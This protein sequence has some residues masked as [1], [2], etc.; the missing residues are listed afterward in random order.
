[1]VARGAIVDQSGL[2]I[3]CANP[4]V[5]AKDHQWVTDFAAEAAAG[6]RAAV[7]LDFNPLLNPHIDRRALLAM[8]AELD[9]RAFAIE[10]LGQ[11]RGPKDAVAYNWV[12]L[13]NERPVPEDFIDVTEQFLELA[14]EGSGISH[15]V[16]LDVQRIPY[17]GGPWYK[18][19]VR[20]GDPISENSVIAWIVGETVLEGGDE[21]EFCDGMRDRGLD[22][23]STLIVCD[24]SGR[25]KHSRRT[26]SNISPEWSGQGSFDTIRGEGFTRIVPPDRRMNRNPAIVD[27]VRAFTSMISTGVGVRRL[28]ADPVKAPKTSAAIRNW[29]TKFGKASR[30]QDEAHLG[31]GASYPIVRLF[32]RRLRASPKSGNQPA[33]PDPVIAKTEGPGFAPPASNETRPGERLR[34]LPGGRGRTRGL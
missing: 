25:Y 22:P 15:L 32:P 18:F 34:I 6:R 13:E 5:E 10:V 21:V 29:R 3:V 28:F 4:P 19:F 12:R 26:I 16:G 20:P 7:Y 27:R 24:A 14:G 2:V 8:K 1:V 30:T 11:F 23:A 17:I 33:V 9:E 31:D